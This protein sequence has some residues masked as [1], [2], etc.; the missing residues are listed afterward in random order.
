MSKAW[1]RKANGTCRK[2]YTFTK[3][4]KQ[5]YG[6]IPLQGLGMKLRWPSHRLA[7]TEAFS[8]KNK[9]M[10]INIGIQL[11]QSKENATAL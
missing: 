2:L 6:E 3:D 11:F 4:N 1:A 9:I 8:L 10:G 5:N 7:T